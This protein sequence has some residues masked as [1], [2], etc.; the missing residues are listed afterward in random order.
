MD[1]GGQGEGEGTAANGRQQ[2]DTSIQKYAQQD[3]R[4]AAEGPVAEE[5]HRTR[6]SGTTDTLSAERVEPDV[7]PDP[8]GV[9]GQDAG[10][11]VLRGTTPQRKR[12]SLRRP[13]SEG[14][15]IV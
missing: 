5:G 9:P 13:S 4:S 15:I 11:N 12:S 2:Q 10:L 1:G 14:M 6:R 7:D 3:T 8:E